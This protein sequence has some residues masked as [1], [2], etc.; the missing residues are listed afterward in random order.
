M[1]EEKLCMHTHAVHWSDLDTIRIHATY[2]GCVAW[3]KGR[4]MNPICIRTTFGGGG[5]GGW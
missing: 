2:S 3:M 4:D 1:G 5:G